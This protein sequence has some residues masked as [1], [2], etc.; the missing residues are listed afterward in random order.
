M[1]I[2]THEEAV[3]LTAVDGRDHV[4]ALAIRAMELTRKS[5]HVWRQFLTVVAVVHLHIDE[6]VGHSFGHRVHKE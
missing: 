1:E 5:V 3:F 4:V 2:L 6:P